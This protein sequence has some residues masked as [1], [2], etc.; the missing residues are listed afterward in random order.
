MHMLR[1]FIGDDAFFEG[2]SQYLKNREFKP[3][4]YHHLR[5]ALEDVTGTDLNWFF[6]DWFET[7]GHPT[8]EVRDSFDATNMTYHIITSQVQDLDEN[9]VYRLPM[10]IALITGAESQTHNIEIK[11]LNDTFSFNGFTSRPLGFNIDVDNVIL[12]DWDIRQDV[13]AWKWIA[14]YSNRYLDH[15]KILNAIDSNNFDLADVHFIYDELLKKEFWGSRLAALEQINLYYLDYAD[16]NF[17][18]MKNLALNDPKSLVRAKAVMLLGQV[19]SMDNTVPV[20]EEAMKDS[21]FAVLSSALSALAKLDSAKSLQAA[22][23]LYTEENDNIYTAIA[24][25]FMDWGGKEWN[26]DIRNIMLDELSYNEALQ[27]LNYYGDYLMK[28]EDDAFLEKNLD[29]YENMVDRRSKEWHSYFLRDMITV[30][31]M[32]NNMAINDLEAEEVL[33]DEESKA[34]EKK[35]SI[36]SKLK[37]QLDKVM[38]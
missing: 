3:A 15:I 12:A 10:K 31:Y 21:S 32:I 14:R 24:D 26:D 1:S 2:V 7:S 17:S 18:K 29:V 28:F 22:K 38:Q 35:K 23:R 16:Q 13:S 37:K 9:A 4:E 20:I 19:Y 8:I 11:N 6:K 30:P 27:V 25:V 36:A 5:L 33:S 34:L